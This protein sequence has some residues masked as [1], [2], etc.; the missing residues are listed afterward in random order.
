MRL[1]VVIVNYRSAQLALECLDSLAQERDAMPTLEVAVVE[2]D[3]PD[4]S[5]ETLSAAIAA[6]GWSEWVHLE[7]SP[8]NGGFGFG[9]NVAV[10]RGLAAPSPPDG[11]LLLNPDTYVRDGAVGAL[12]EAL[13]TDPAVGIVGSRLEDPDGTVQHSR[14]RFPSLCNA[15]DD[16]LRLGILHRLL[17]D[18]VTCPPH[19]ETAHDIDWLAGASMLIRREVFELVGLFD[20]GFFLYYEELDFTRR[21]HALGVRTRYVPSSRVVHL[22]GQSTGVTSRNKRPGRT[23]GY[24]FES[25]KRYFK[26]HHSALYKLLADAAFV[27]GRSIHHVLRVLRRRPNLEPPRYLW[28]FVRNNWLPG[29]RARSSWPR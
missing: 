11:F 1:T 9:V 8:H 6:R 10:R 12:V 21:A 24:W 16:G 27:L 22:V 26:K 3:S 7:K 29:G 28:D 4:D 14:F 20:E 17:G 18:R 23:P 13:R 15:L 25:R 2:N 5:Y 19:T